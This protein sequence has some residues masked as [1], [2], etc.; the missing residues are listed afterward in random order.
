[1]GLYYFY[2]VLG[3]IAAILGFFVFFYVRP[4]YQRI[5]GLIIGFSGIIFVIVA[6]YVMKMLRG[7]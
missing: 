2:I 3:I 4:L 1:M 5:T 7:G 6:I